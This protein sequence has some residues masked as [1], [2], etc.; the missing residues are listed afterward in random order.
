MKIS[1]SPNEKLRLNFLTG[2]EVPFEKNEKFGLSFIG[3]DLKTSETSH[4]WL[5]NIEDNDKFMSA[6]IEHAIKF[7]YINI[8]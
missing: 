6:C 1:I 2:K 3:I 7:E 5:Y 4:T 8:L